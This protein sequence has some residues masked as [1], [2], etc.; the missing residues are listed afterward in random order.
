MKKSDKIIVG[1]SVGDLNGVGSEIILK[2][3][4]DARMFDS[5]TPVVF[6]N[7][8]LISYVNKS[9][10]TNVSVQPIESLDQIVPN[11]LNVLNVW[12]ENVIVE[13]GQYNAELGKYAVA[14]FKS[15]TQA[16]KEGRVDVLVTAPINKHAVDSDDFKFV[17]HTEYLDQ[18]LSGEAL[19]LLVSE[20]LRVGLVTGHVS[21]GNVVNK[22]TKEAIV[23]KVAVLEES[24]KRDFGISRPKIALLSINPHCGDGGVIGKE[25]DE[26]VVPLVSE[27]FDQGK[28]VF[29]PF[30]A[31][32]FFGAQLYKKY[33]A[34]L[35]MYHDQGLIPFKA[36]AFNSGVNFTVGLDKIRTSPD[37]G[38]AFDIAGKN[39]ADHSS[40]AQAV[41]MAMDAFHARE[42]YAELTKNPLKIT[43]KQSESKK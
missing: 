30:A 4:E 43:E 13:F 15:A 28:L 25:D 33:D 42:E 23:K 7:S 31:D 9:L 36:L 16:L 34:V 21:L 10:G 19:M 22:I 29:G 6:A 1:I 27:L 5:C 37:H 32:G 18:E 24:L 17:G 3:F 14:S 39:K 8:K 40:F 41:Y 35:A 38:T 20:E 26:L 11:K 12:K 2:T